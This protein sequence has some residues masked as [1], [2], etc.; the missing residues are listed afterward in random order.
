[1]L[2]SPEIAMTDPVPAQAADSMFAR[3]LLSAALG[4]ASV[5]PALAAADSRLAATT[6]T[7]PAQITPQ[8]PSVIVNE[9]PSTLPSYLRQVHE[10]GQM[11][12]R[13]REG[14]L[15]QLPR[16]AAKVMIANPAIA[17][18]QVPTPNSVFV[19]AQ[20]AGTTTLYA[21]DASDQVIAAIRIVAEYNLEE[22][23]AQITRAV[24]GAAVE[25]EPALNGR[26]IVR[27]QVRTPIEARQVVD[28]VQAYLD[29]TAAAT[30]GGAG[31]GAAAG[32]GGGGAAAGG[33]AGGN[34]ANSRVI[35]QLKVEL[36][37]Q[38]NI[39]VRVVEVSRSLSHELGFDWGAML[40]SGSGSLRFGSGNAASLFDANGSSVVLPA[41]STSGASIGGVLTRGRFSI[42]TMISAMAQ[43]GMATLLAEPNLTAMSGESAAFAAG[44]EVPVV[45]ITNNNTT[46]DYKSYGVILRMTPTLLSPNR[47]SLHIAPEVSELTDEGSVTLE[48]GST[49]PALKV[50]RADTTVELAS[51]Q[52]FALGGMLRSAVSQQLETV[53]GLSKIPVL[54][55]LFEHETSAKEDTELVILV[56]ANV[57][58]PVGPNELQVPGQGLPTIDEFQP[59]QAAAGY[60]Y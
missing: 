19:F 49:I 15:L 39:Q 3:A 56:T 8:R 44:G 35:N 14:N 22:L 4:L 54:G 47:I 57:V 12:L 32:G 10:S 20:T 18:F 21:L 31:G 36:S 25:L 37:S 41:A 5:A 60:L 48:S 50:R 16:A 2:P 45:I 6:I 27:G 33:G 30:P 46:I 17:N 51:G 29:S 42:S 26:M 23:R 34:N 40:S 52:S 1:M 9:H 7:P 38:V 13:V 58:D 24:P 53:P 28:Q 59:R 55:R 43:D 11:T